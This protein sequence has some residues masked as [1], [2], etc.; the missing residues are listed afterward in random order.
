M[1]EASRIADLIQ[2]Q[3]PAL[4]SGSLRF[5]GQWFG[6]PMD[7]LHTVT[8]ASADGESLEV[9]F[10]NGETLRVVRPTGWV[11]AERAFRIDNAARLRWEWNAYG[12]PPG[13]RH[14][15]EYV[16]NGDDIEAT[17]DV[18]WYVPSLQPSATEPAVVIL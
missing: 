7:N 14:F 4:K 11:I 17:T 8:G 15:E 10:D 1:T 5:W 3:L 6:R 18:D 9:R 16:R 2:R 12:N 13:K